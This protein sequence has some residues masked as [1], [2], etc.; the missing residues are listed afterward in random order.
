LWKLFADNMPPKTGAIPLKT[1][2]NF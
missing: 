1:L 2:S